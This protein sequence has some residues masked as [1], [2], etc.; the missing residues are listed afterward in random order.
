MADYLNIRVHAFMPKSSANGP[1]LR[2][3]IWFQGCPFNC[4]GCFNPETHDPAGG[5][6]VSA[7]N[8]VQKVLRAKNET[9]G[10]TI[11]GGEPFYQPEGLLK[12]LRKI[13]QVSELS[14]LVFSGYEFEK[15][16]AEPRFSVCLPYIDALICGPYM[17]DR[18][19]A[20]ERF[21]SSDNQQLIL[22]SGYFCKNDFNGLP[23][24][25]IIVQPGGKIIFS[26]IEDC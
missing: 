10:I 12:I 15:I 17:K 19:P 16:Q 5:K 1:G 3:V 23:T 22:T 14:V 2:S 18:P 26:G 9:D 20:Y 11:S 8:I 13:R 25:E 6:S 7:E 4:P 21:C 24:E